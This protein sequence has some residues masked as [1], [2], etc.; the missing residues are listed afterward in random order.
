MQTPNARVSGLKA[1]RRDPYRLLIMTIF[2]ALSLLAVL[3]GCE[4]A[5]T[6][7]PA[8]HAWMLNIASW[9]AGALL[10]T[11]LCAGRIDIR[12]WWPVLALI[13]L[14]ST[15]LEPGLS[16]VHRWISLGPVRLNSAELLLAPMIVALADPNP[17]P[18]LRLIVVF[19]ALAI[20]IF[21]PDA[22]QAIALAG[23]SGVVM[24]ASPQ[25]ALRR[26]VIVIG[27]AAM[28]TA[29][30]FRPDPLAPVPEVEGIIQLAANQ[31]T[32]VAGVAV[33]ALVGAIV[34]PLVAA[35][36]S[37]PGLRSAC[38][39]LT[40]YLALS[41]LAPF[42]GRFPVPLVGMGVS[43]I[44]GAWLGLGALMAIQGRRDQ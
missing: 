34:T 16:G 22:S 2:G 21:Q 3:I 14:A 7:A 19:S 10:G 41:A 40:S 18:S 33:L 4:V 11:A 8:G 42:C 43:S 39:G 29:S 12:R 24:L 25:T 23:G 5:H 1:S 31:S 20:L 17:N 30:L 6:S 26:A 15:F 13:G 36:R 27:L 28:A 38:Y 35:H 9:I 32:A 44:L 37:P